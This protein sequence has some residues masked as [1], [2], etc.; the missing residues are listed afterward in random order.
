MWEGFK[1]FICIYTLSSFKNYKIGSAVL[2]AF[3][4]MSYM[5]GY[6]MFT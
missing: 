2:P 4:F 3:R 5:K 1:I 6:I